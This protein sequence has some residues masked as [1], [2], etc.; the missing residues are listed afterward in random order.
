MMYGFITAL[1]II[2]VNLI[3]YITG[4]AF[5]SW[6]QYISYIPFLLG[7]IL[8]A[9]AFSKAN[10]NFVSFGNVFRSCFKASAIITL[11]VLAWSFISLA[12][13][14]DIVEK[15][16]EMAREGMVKRGMSDEQIEKG[17]GFMAK[18]FKLFMAMGVI[19]WEMLMG[20]IFSLIGAAVAKKKG[21][22][23]IQTV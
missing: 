18:S 19:F 20:A 9:N 10:D 3:L 2:I 12:I 15:A 22:A 11:C 8:N 16:M 4:N 14:P 1:A 13:F 6:S 17:M 21:N 5:R 23:P 7:I